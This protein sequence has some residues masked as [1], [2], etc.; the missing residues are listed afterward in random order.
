MKILHCRYG[1]LY[2]GVVPQLGAAL[3]YFYRLVEGQREDI[4]RPASPAALAQREVC[5]TASFPLLPFCNRIRDGR[6]E[7]NGQRYQLA[8]NLPPSAH[9]I[10]GVGWQS[11]WTVQA[12]NTDAVSLVLDY[13]PEAG[14]P[15]WPWRFRA[16]LEYRLDA[17]GL[18][19]RTRLL[20]QDSHAMPFGIGHHPYF[21]RRTGQLSQ[22]QVSAMWD[23]DA[24]RLPTR[25]SSP[26]F[27][28]ELA[29]GID[30]NALDLDHHFCGWDGRARL[31]TANH[32]PSLELYAD[33]H[34]SFL[35]V[36]SPHD[37]NFFCLEPVSQVA[38]ASNLLVKGFDIK[39][40]GGGVLLPGERYE[41]VW[42]MRGV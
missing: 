24:E 31:L 1:D 36:Y 12:C 8:A 11:A 3:S 25:L 41:A 29:Q 37:A 5:G 2:L 20:N 39:E 42:G 19:V 13:V 35:N 17:Q 14:I 7:F 34:F 27:L 40:V 23:S 21:P 4:L 22:A 30:L 16:E 38:D 9:A 28:S 32:A 33:A 18:R 10:H 15:R 26:P 6:F